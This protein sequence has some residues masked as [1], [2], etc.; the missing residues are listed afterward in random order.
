M[1]KTK[2]KVLIYAEYKLL[3]IEICWK[4]LYKIQYA[5]KILMLLANDLLIR[6]ISSA[7]TTQTKYVSFKELFI[8]QCTHKKLLKNKE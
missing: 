8:M 1:I 4:A 7:Q 3:V 5:L 6:H 2:N